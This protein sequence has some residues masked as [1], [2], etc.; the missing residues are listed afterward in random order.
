LTSEEVWLDVGMLISAKIIS[1][2]PA[3]LFSRS[4]Y[5]DTAQCITIWLSIYYFLLARSFFY[6][7][8]S[9][10]LNV[11]SNCTRSVVPFQLFHCAIFK[12]C[13]ILGG[14]TSLVDGHLR[15]YFGWRIFRSKDVNTNRKQISTDKIT[16]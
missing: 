1:L 8:D 2:L 4:Q 11:N 10:S 9:G 5:A 6:F 7:T 15:L 14:I 3:R 12:D 16:Q 13:D